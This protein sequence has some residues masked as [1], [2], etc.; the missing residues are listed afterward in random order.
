MNI[1]EK[2][3]QLSNQIAQLA[4]QQTGMNK[5]LIE[6][7]DELDRVKAEAASGVVQP[8][9]V[10]QTPPSTELQP[11]AEPHPDSYPDNYRDK[12]KTQPSLEE[13]IGGNLA[14]KVGILITLIGI[15]IGAKYAIEHNLVSPVV[16][17]TSGYVSGLLLI[18]IAWRLKKR[19]EQYSAVLMGGGL[20][21]M[22]F[23]T[24]TAYS[25]YDLF[26]QLLAFIM[27]LVFTV[28]A[29]YAALLYN[30][31]VIAHLGLVGAYAIPILLSDNAGRYAVLF[32]YITIINT[33]ILILSFKKYWKSLFH[34]SFV[35]TW[36][37]YGS[38]F[39]FLQRGEHYTTG[40][41]F[42]CI[43]FL[44]FYTTFL[45]YKLIKKEQY[46][47]KDVILLLSN[48]FIF[49][50]YGYGLLTRNDESTTVLGLFTLA[51]A[52]IHF[53]VSMVVKRMQLAD[54]A[55]FYL[56]LG[57]VI[58]FITIA[59]PVQLDGNWVTL[60]WTIEA[61]IVFYI[62]R[63]QQR[64]GYER[65]AVFITLIAFL[66]LLQ[67]WSEL[68]RHNYFFNTTF[69]TGILV[70]I[71]FGAMLYL[72]RNR[73][74]IYESNSTFMHLEFYNIALPLLF[75][76]TAYFTFELELYNYFGF[77]ID[78]VTIPDWKFEI[79]LFRIAAL[80]LYSMVFA[81]LVAYCN[82]RWTKNKFLAGATLIASLLCIAVLLL[83][84]M[85]AL[86]ELSS[87]YQNSDASY[88]GAGN[89]LIRYVTIAMA[90][91]LLWLG[92][93]AF[94]LLNTDPALRNLHIVITQITVLTIISFEYL[95]WMNLIGTSI[96]EYKFGL[97]II[98]SVYALALVVMGINKKK[99]YWRL[100]GIF[101]F[102][103]TLIK[104]FVYDL[105]QATTISKTIS[106]LSLGAILLLVSYLYNRYK[107]VILEED[108]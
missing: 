95:Q 106:F 30:R 29:V 63:T 24:Y 88:F 49:Y 7:M 13:F 23:I 32:T 43:F 61:L 1:Q 94:S 37:I 102:I 33:G 16:R 26:P 14:S 70:S 47:V 65:L 73:K 25:F 58:A 54:K 83:T 40:M 76:G 10:Q 9:P 81:A 68:S 72:H 38:F 31:M 55:L 53:A 50:G 4:Q 77:L 19:Y 41:V 28:A 27:M 98:W 87:H 46:S 45:A 78:S 6:L 103:V 74:A 91:V 97:S 20:S 67:D 90:G 64:P 51:N 21:V 52:A 69:F 100:T 34:V 93:K 56:L 96:N 2:I 105:S 11:S 89:L 57:L 79:E 62:G 85:Y 86:N 99:K 8:K 107:Q 39:I 59:I 101:F 80:L 92:R 5:R 44:I 22:Y 108:E 36:L 3:E 84:G 104:L 48:A 15:F 42:L 18:G 12:P 66:S 82:L 71:G 17:I 60:L 35:F 75:L